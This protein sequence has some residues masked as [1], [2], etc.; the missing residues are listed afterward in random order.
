MTLSLWAIRRPFLPLLAIALCSLLG[1]LSLAQMPLRHLPALGH[2]TVTARIAAPGLTLAETDI[3]LAQPAEA[4]LGTL[5]GVTRSHTEI[6]AGRLILTLSL[7]DPAHAEAV[8]ATLR[9]RLAS[10]QDRLT[11]ATDPAVITSVSSRNQPAARVALIPGPDGM[12]LIA[13]QL[14]PQLQRLPGVDSVI[15]DGLTQPEIAIQPDQTRLAELGLT[16]GDL[17]RQITARLAASGLGVATGSPDLSLAVT[18]GTGRTDPRAL[19]DMPITL[20]TTQSLPLS[21]L[22]TVT[23]RDRPQTSRARLNGQP[24]VI[25]TVTPASHADLPSLLSA[26]DQT[27]N[28]FDAA[29]PGHSPRLIDRQADTVT[30]ALRATGIALLEGALLVL[31]TVWL[32]L[33][34]ARATAIAALALPLSILPTFLAM[35]ILGFSLNIISLL[36]ITLAAGIL[37]DDAIV[38][39]ENIQAHLA[40]GDRPWTATVKATRGIGLAVV[41][42]TLAIVAV[43]L[44]VTLLPGMAGRYFLEFGGTLSIAAL[45]SLFVA[46]MVI[47]PIAAR[48]IASPFAAPIPPSP[49]TSS[50][51]QR[52]LALGLRHPLLGVGLT[53][54]LILASVVAVFRHPGDFIPPEDTGRLTI[55][56]DLPATS[57]TSTMDARLDAIATRLASIAGVADVTAIL[58]DATATSALLTV[59][60]SPRAL[61][62]QPQAAIAAQIAALLAT[63]P[64]LRALVLGQTGRAPAELVLAGNDPARLDQAAAAIGTHLQ[65]SLSALATNA[66]AK[67]Q[68]TRRIDPVAAAQAG[69]TRADATAEL[70]LF[71]QDAPP[72]ATLAG[73]DGRPV[74]LRLDL[75]ANALSL[76]TLRN[77]T[78]QLIPLS[79]IATTDI[80]LV[81]SRLERQDGLTLRRLTAA[82]AP[83]ET[84]AEATI[85]LAAARADRAPDVLPLATGDTA[86]RAEMME[87]LKQAMLAGLLLLA[88]LLYA[89]YRSVGQVMVVLATLPLSLGG[90]LIGLAL[91]GQGLSLPVILAMLLLLGI[92]AKNAILIVDA[93]QSAIA[94][95]TAPET[96]LIAAC[97]SRA[98]PVIMTSLAI[99]GGMLPAALGLGAGAGFRQPLAI[100]VISGITV[101]TALS[102][103][104]VPILSLQ[105][106]RSTAALARLSRL[107]AH[108]P[109]ADTAH[110]A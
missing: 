14:L 31:A 23:A 13:T 73:T 36:A 46:R 89:L 106:H 84:A 88:A 20:G 8:K 38:E 40:K 60:L 70:R 6:T 32:A 55:A 10:L 26:L 2:D 105:A 61:R 81:P 90:A 92:V 74:T 44:P 34:S 97:Q 91:A 101:A 45:V 103:F 78:G 37:V 21:E 85:R 75:S 68:Q 93:A 16:A 30:A 4:A 51:Y 17:D 1:L 9:D 72:L 22:A 57:S 24:A 104:V 39:V 27:I 63:E 87:A 18:D 94:K 41:A 76:T 7:A 19:R 58:P 79:A 62:D 15:A 77:S 96:A 5:P 47:P 83:G 53:L 67:A 49:P 69:V 65:G 56:L 80:A 71:S 54:A 25:L 59:E 66:P 43:F 102:L 107:I 50:R 86:Q 33:R 82:P 110:A 42:T 29:H 64:D 28:R 48:W 11:I 99:I 108:N 100:A 98:R 12:A 109:K 3:A 52:L 95:G 35:D